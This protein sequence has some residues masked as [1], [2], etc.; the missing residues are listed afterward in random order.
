MAQ[1]ERRQ[2]PIQTPQNTWSP[3]LRTGS[4]RKTPIAPSKISPQSTPKTHSNKKEGSDGTPSRKLKVGFY[5]FKE[6]FF[7]KAVL[8]ENTINRNFYNKFVV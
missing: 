7:F 2:L 6:S 5:F 8:Q 3:T 1:L 4:Q